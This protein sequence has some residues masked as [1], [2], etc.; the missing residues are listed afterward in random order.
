MICP[1]CLHKFP[2]TWR[3]YFKS[4]FGRHVCPACAKVSRLPF[5]YSHFFF[6]LVVGL[7]CAAPGTAVLL[8]LTS[9]F[10]AVFGIIPTILI[11]LPLDMLLDAKF[12]Q[13]QKVEGEEQPSETASCG[14]CNGTFAKRDLIAHQGV[15]ICARCKPVFLQKLAEGAPIGLSRNS[16]KS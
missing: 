6:L 4:T 5:K 16:K 2:L 3:R 12:K 10:W 1:Y 7:I 9:D 14:E 13:L 15:F 11:V 8:Y